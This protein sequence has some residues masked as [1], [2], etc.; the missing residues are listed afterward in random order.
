M[1]AIFGNV[2]FIGIP[3]SSAVLGPKSLIFVSICGLTFNLIIYTYGA[4]SMK[5]TAREQHPEEDTTDGFSIKNIINSGTVMAVVTI[6][7]YLSDLK[8]PKA[9]SSTLT[10]I[11]NC[12]TFLSMIV[13]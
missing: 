13:L 1:L 5:M 9:V 12:T 10:Y 8:V 2:G 11:G 6:I 3:F 4:A 7:V